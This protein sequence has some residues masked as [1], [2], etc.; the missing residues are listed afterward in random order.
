MLGK[1]GL[2]IETGASIFANIPLSFSYA[3][4][5]TMLAFQEWWFACLEW[6]LIID[7]Y[8]Q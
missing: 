2:Y 5:V 4:F 7:W 1:T 8:I 3:A 6:F